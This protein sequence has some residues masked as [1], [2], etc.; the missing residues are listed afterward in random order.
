MYLGR[1]DRI[2]SVTVGQNAD[3]MV[4]RGDLG[5]RISD[6]ENV[7]VIFRDGLGFDSARLL[8]S[9]RG[10]FGLYRGCL[11]CLVDKAHLISLHRGQVKY[12]SMKC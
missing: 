8:E 2:R 6:I 3:L 7:E 12:S 4:V 1:A 9:V 10:H 5:S 11:P